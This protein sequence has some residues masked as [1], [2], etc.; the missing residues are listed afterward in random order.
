MPLRRLVRLIWEYKPRIVALD[1]IY[2]LAPSER[3]LARIISMFPDTV[4]IVQVTRAPD[5]TL[6]DLRTL[7]SMLGINVGPKLSPQKTAY[8]V[9]LLAEKGYGSRVR[10]LEEKTKIVIRRGRC[11]SEGGMSQQRYQRRLRAA[12]L[13]ATKRVK[14]LLDKHK[15]D[16]DLVF[17]KSGG[18]LDSAVF[19]VYAPRDA[20]NGIIKPHNGNDIIVEIKPV[21]SSHIVF[22]RPQRHHEKPRYLI[23]GIDPGM[24]TA[25][26]GIDLEG[27]LVFVESRRG[28]DRLSIIELIYRHGIPVL[29]A[30]DV[31]PAPDLVRKLASS[32]H[33]PLFEAPRDMR[34][35]EKQELVERFLA[36]QG[37]KI[38]LD[39]HQRDALAAA[40]KAYHS[41]ESKLR[42]AESYVLKLGLDV[43]VEA[44]KAAIVRGA[45]L[46]E[47]I[48]EE[49]EKRIAEAEA[50][51]V[52]QKRVV[53][54]PSSEDT[55]RKAEER[56]RARLEE[57]EAENRRLQLRIKMLEEEIERLQGELR[58]VKAELDPKLEAERRIEE[59]K[60][61]LDLVRRE[62]ESLRKEK[63][64]LQDL[65]RKTVN[66]VLE[67]GL[68]RAAIGF[69]LPL[70]S[71]EKVK[72]LVRSYGDYLRGALIVIEEV[73]PVYLDQIDVLLEKGI[74][75]ILL[76]RC[77]LE[78]KSSFEDKHVP[79]LPLE[80]YLIEKLGPLAILK[81]E[82]YTEAALEKIS[83]EE[84]KRRE[85]KKFL[86]KDE[87]LK[88]F[89]EYRMQRARELFGET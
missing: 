21:Y 74:A 43:D 80:D 39:S 76:P 78:Y 84:R 88:M 49:I 26:A 79:V 58:L 62:L 37:I 25:V 9:A 19:I 23:V 60:R 72:E 12:I 34:V 56:L 17:R 47:A 46:A 53:R 83:L 63:T 28:M 40:I 2:E 32:L 75:G 66:Y 7:A 48:E 57:L 65:F 16:Y 54:R 64:E 38:Q 87:L 51:P 44:V 31:K 22:E 73:N 42:Q 30:S 55:S 8:I 4:E 6:Y 67:I 71:P 77:R 36:R 52:L 13:R 68:G 14:E 15:F 81:P 70:L 89:E 18:G 5:G 10:F 27:R 61:T 1:N 24:Y 35:E 86:S 3:E 45:S 50:E 33:V 85:E 59:L 11:G 69:V 82:A 20:L 29:I 41:L